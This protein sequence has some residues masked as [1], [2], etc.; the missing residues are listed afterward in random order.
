[1]EDE[2]ADTFRPETPIITESGRERAGAEPGERDTIMIVAL[3]GWNDAGN[4]AST[5]VAELCDYW[6]ATE[7]AEFESDVFYD[8]QFTRP[9]IGRDSDGDQSIKWPG[10]RV[11]KAS[12]P[13]KDLDAVI[14]LGVEPSFRWHRFVD[15]VLH[16]GRTAAGVILLGALLADV[17]HSRPIPVSV[18]S[19]DAN[20]RAALNIDVN[21]YEGPT[22]VI[23]V[24][25]HAAAGIKL[26]TVSLW[27]AVPS[28]VAQ[29]PSPK[30]QL[31][32][33]S[34]IEELLQV[35]IPQ[36]ELIDDARAWERGV[37]ELA[38]SDEDVASYIHQLEQV[39]D[40][41]DLPEASG[42]A[43]AQEFEKYLRRNPP[44]GPKR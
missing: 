5:A 30:A 36:H 22:G 8:Y 31:A 32:L 15:T 43:I 16:H 17:P 41:T 44:D 11:Y 20:L 13:G 28:Y 38:D 40:T 21:H 3:E 26:P 37:N 12:V 33:V 2:S 7:I 19:E 27:A 35:S 14:V 25:A 4:A 42:E 10:T 6:G 39:Q 24:L 9:M 34:K 1:M 18:S 29:P 23:G